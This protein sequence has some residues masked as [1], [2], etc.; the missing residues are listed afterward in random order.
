MNNS[1]KK[2]YL[3]PELMAVPIDQ[4]ITLVM[5]S[6]PGGGGTPE[7]PLNAPANPSSTVFPNSTQEG[8]FGSGAPVYEKD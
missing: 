6:D 5:F 2:R 4:E 1:A 7:D 8:V 3:K